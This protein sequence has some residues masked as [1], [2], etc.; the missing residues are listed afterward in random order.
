MTL[1]SNLTTAG[2][3]VSQ[4]QEDGNSITWST[5]PTDEQM[6]LCRDI[7]LQYVDPTAQA[8]IQ[9][10]R[11]DRAQIKAELQATITQLKAIED[12]V[13]PTNAQVIAAV[14]FLART[15]RLMLKL[16]ARTL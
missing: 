4:A 2:L 12:A 14:K 3:P 11:A 8:D 5:P 7:V 16:L 13:S 9:A 10:G 6:Q 1:L 15:L